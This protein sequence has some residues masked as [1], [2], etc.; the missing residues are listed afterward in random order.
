M[1]FEVGF[2]TPY[3]VTSFGT[4]GTA[5]CARARVMSFYTPY[6]VTSFGTAQQS[7]QNR[8]RRSGFY[9]P[10][11]VTSFGTPRCPPAPGSCPGFLYALRRDLVWDELETLV[12]SCII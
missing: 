12:P 2:Y 7:D 10:Y 3:G 1:T 9:T 6:G 11:G 4:A 5:R 8:A